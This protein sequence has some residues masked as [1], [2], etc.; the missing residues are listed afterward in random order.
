METLLMSMKERRRLVVLSQVKLGQLTVSAAAHRLNLSERQA[1]RVWRRYCQNG[2]AGLIHRLR[3]RPGNRQSDSYKRSQALE[4]YKLHY[5]D[6]GCTLACEY[7]Q[8]RHG[9]TVDDQTLRRWL[10]SAGL[11]HRRRR[12][13]SQHRRRLRKPCFGELVQL[14][15]S[16]HAWF[17]GRGDLDQCVLMVMIDDATGWTL[18]RFFESETTLAAM[19]LF[20]HWVNQYGLPGTVYPDRHSIYRV[21][22]KQA[23]EIQLRTGKRP[24]T[25]FGR[26]MDELGV[27]LICAKTPQ[28]K[29][30]VE[31][32]NGTL[33]DRLVKALRLEGI[34]DITSANEF[35]ESTFLPRL[36]AKFVVE[37][38]DRRDVH[39]PVA[40]TVLDEAMC[41]QTP[42][43]VGRDHCVS[44]DGQVLQLFPGSMNLASKRVQVRQDLTGQVSV[45]WRGQQ[46][47]YA[48]VPQRLVR[49]KLSLVDRVETHARPWKPPANHPWRG[50]TELLTEVE[51]SSVPARATPSPPL[52]WTQ[53]PA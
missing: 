10:A 45:W 41:V 44:W 48:P 46:I 21:N 11:W 12:G 19:T 35:L 33:Q 38:T 3:G 50:H 30:R 37:P 2:D 27:I 23:D 17:E 52:R 53:P 43:V 31:R 26:A 13:P 8:E 51:P 1:R 49:P 22:T 20:R 28:A 42:R 18:A 29:G 39:V 47:R 7:L 34:C 14:D 6:F 24:P 4:L 9:L 25:Q 15:G 40:R 32:M 16:H 5:G 36:N